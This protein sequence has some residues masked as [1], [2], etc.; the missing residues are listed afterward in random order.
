MIQINHAKNSS[1]VDLNIFYHLY[2]NNMIGQSLDICLLWFNVTTS[3][4]YKYTLIV[5]IIRV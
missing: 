1:D 2:I 4:D 5:T 3:T